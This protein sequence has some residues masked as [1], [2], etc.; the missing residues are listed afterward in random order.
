M[1]LISQQKKLS[2]E[3]NRKKLLSHLSPRVSG[4]ELPDEHDRGLEEVSPQQ[5]V[6]GLTDVLTSSHRS[7]KK[8]RK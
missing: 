5:R 7:A 1:F 8:I 6:V 4:V 2:N 3:F